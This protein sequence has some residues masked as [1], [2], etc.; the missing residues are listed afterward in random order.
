MQLIGDVSMILSSQLLDSEK[1]ISARSC[2]VGAGGAGVNLA[3]ELDGAGVSLILLEASGTGFFGRVSQD[4]YADTAT[5]GHLPP[6]QFR[7]HGFGAST[8]IWDGHCIPAI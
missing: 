6:S 8:T 7:R 2:I 1:D 3:W 4:P 5:G